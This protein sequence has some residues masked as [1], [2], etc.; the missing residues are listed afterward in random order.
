[1][2]IKLQLTGGRGSPDERRRDPRLEVR[3]PVKLH[4]PQ[5]GRYWAGQ[6]CNISPGGAM[7]EVAHPSL[8]VAGQGLKLGVAWTNRQAL[9][10]PGDMVDATVVRSLGG[11]GVQYVAVRFAQRMPA[12]LAV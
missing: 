4:C 12:A 9:L 8:L 2:G 11:G 1:M 6:T 3:H 10:G 5:T 7:V